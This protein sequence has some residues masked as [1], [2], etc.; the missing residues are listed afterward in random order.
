M[1][2]KIQENIK[3]IHLSV[4]GQY[5]L[6]KLEKNKN[7]TNIKLSRKLPVY[8][9]ELPVFSAKLPMFHEK[10]PAIYEFFKIKFYEV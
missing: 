10:L 7:Y 1:K 9:I 2:H 6:T 4:L 5:L 3:F 8:C